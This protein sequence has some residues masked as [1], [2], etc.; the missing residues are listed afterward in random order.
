MSH[1][2][3]QEGALGFF[4]SISYLQVQQFSNI[5]TDDL[6]FH[7]KVRDSLFDGNIFT[8]ISGVTTLIEFMVPKHY[9]AH[10]QDPS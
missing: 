8:I 10:S 3:K 6:E 4:G 5:Y 2:I 7:I 1:T 9:L